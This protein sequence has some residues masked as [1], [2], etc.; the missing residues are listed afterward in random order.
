MEHYRITEDVG[1]YFVTFTVIE[2]MPV[3]IDETTCK[4][5]TDCLNFSVRSK[6]LGVNA[7][8][9]MPN[10]MHAIVFDLDFDSQRLKRTLDDLRKFTGRQLL[11]YADGRLSDVFGK[12]FRNNAGQDRQR[13]FWQSTQHP[14]GIYTEK[15]YL[16]KMNYIHL[17]PVR[18]GLV[19]LPE[20]W[21]FSSAAFWRRGE[22]ENDVEL[23]EISWR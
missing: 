2:W 1:V 8:V 19:R 15:F 4:I 22:L 6:R 10:H 9:I 23:S 3:F 14:E 20:D 13:K 17:N 16:Q 21:R 11:D 5:I 7:Y 18:K 12:T